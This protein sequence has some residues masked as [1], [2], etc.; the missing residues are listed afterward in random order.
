M[1]RKILSLSLAFLFKRQNL[2]TIS[3]QETIIDR[4]AQSTIVNRLIHAPIGRVH[5]IGRGAI[6][7][8]N[9]TMLDRLLRFVI[10]AIKK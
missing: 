6:I 7:E 2:V 4:L 9:A 5:K 10:E 8:N 3:V 1:S